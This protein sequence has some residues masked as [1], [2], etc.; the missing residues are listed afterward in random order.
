MPKE[1]TT[2]ARREIGV[3]V[4]WAHVARGKHK[5]WAVY[6]TKIWGAIKCGEFPGQIDNY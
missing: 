6:N 5:Y 2:H 3:S 4:D 1:F